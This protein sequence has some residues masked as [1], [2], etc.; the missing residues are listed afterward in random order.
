MSTSSTK[1]GKSCYLYTAFFAL[2]WVL[3]WKWVKPTAIPFDMFQFWYLK[4]SIWD[5][6]WMSWPLFAWGVV[7]TIVLTLWR[8]IDFDNVLNAEENFMRGA[9]KSLIA[10]LFE[11][12]SFRWLIFYNAIVGAKISNYLLFGW[13]GFGIL[14]W[15][16]AHLMGP[17]VNFVTFGHLTEQFFSYGWA[18]GAAILISNGDFRDHHAYLGPIGYWNSW[19]VGMF[20]FYLMFHHGILAAIII[21][22]LYDFTIDV[23]NY[24]Y[25]IVVRKKKYS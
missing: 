17:L 3:F 15:T 1:K 4:G 2:L 22:F 20:M 7:G 25:A 8:G 11:E 14:E 21:H 10:G 19:F 12:P 6:L 9:V 24:L 13:A 23:T 18:V 5:I 16:Q